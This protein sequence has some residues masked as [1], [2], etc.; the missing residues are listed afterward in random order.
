M[1]GKFYWM[2]SF[3]IYVLF[4]LNWFH[5]STSP[6]VE[7]QA[8]IENDSYVPVFIWSEKVGWRKLVIKNI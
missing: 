8:D 2:V 1:K 3:K 7:W 5:Q 6:L 4:Y